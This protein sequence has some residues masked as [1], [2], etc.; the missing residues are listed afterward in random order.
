MNRRPHNNELQRT[1]DGNAAASPLNSVF[2]GRSE[3]HMA[4]K[5]VIAFVFVLLF[6]SCA[7][8]TWYA[9]RPE[10][11]RSAYVA[12]AALRPGMAFHDVVVVLLNS[13]RPNQYAA[14]ESGRSCRAASVDI[15]VHSGELLFK[16][17]ETRVYAS[18][19]ASIQTLRDQGF[20]S[21]GFER[22]AALLEAIRTR[23]TEL[24][25]CRA[26][27]LT[28]AAVTEGRYGHDR[29][30]LTFAEDGLLADVGDIQWSECA[31]ER[32][33]VEQ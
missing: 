9:R 19:F 29:I 25:A 24:L 15:V 4:R 27:T 11:E 18:G 33:A 2:D 17:G 16:A 3:G 1:R 6:E 14:L 13:R 8:T 31:S 32:S 5:V 12:A 7:T 30:G 10:A 22:P 21:E 20:R 23:E 28:F 26:A